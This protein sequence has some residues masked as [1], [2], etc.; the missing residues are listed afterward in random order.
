MTV[1]LLSYFGV[2][3]TAILVHQ[4][5]FV[6]QGECQLTKADL[7]LSHQETFRGRRGRGGEQDNEMWRVA[8]SA[9]RERQKSLHSTESACD[10]LS[11]VFCVASV[12]L[13]VSKVMYGL[14]DLANVLAAVIECPLD[15]ESTLDEPSR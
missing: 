4:H 5:D 7:C 2:Q 8:G 13:G 3:T 1:L 9:E 6:F 10:Y 11:S 15:I 14:T 12:H